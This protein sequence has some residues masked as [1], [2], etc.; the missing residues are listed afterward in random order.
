MGKDGIM[1]NRIMESFFRFGACIEP[2]Q[3][4]DENENEDED[5]LDKGCD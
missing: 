1:R 3:I 2:Q 4:E 5:D